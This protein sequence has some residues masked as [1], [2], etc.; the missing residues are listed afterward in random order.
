MRAQQRDEGLSGEMG[1]SSERWVAQEK[2]WAKAK[3]RDIGQ[4]RA[5][6]TIK[7]KRRLY[8]YG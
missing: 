1:G 8:R 6:V 7:R 5:T 2:D 4:G 3:R